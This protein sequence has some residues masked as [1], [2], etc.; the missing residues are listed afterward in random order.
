MPVPCPCPFFLGCNEPG[1]F[2]VS[3]RHL[4]R[5]G[6]EAHC[7][8]EHTVECF[9]QQIEGIPHLRE[10]LRCALCLLALVVLMSD[11]YENAMSRKSLAVRKR[12]G[13]QETFEWGNR[14]PGSGL[15]PET[16]DGTAPGGSKLVGRSFRVTCI[17]QDDL[18]PA[19]WPPLGAVY[20]RGVCEMLQYNPGITHL[21]DRTATAGAGPEI[22]TLGECSIPP[23]N[24]VVWR[25]CNAAR[26]PKTMLGVSSIQWMLSSVAWAPAGTRA[27]PCPAHAVV[28]SVCFNADPCEHPHV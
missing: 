19:W 6:H 20:R 1:D 2:R 4:A 22:R 18:K 15:T 12:L 14:T 10:F 5:A 3:C 27:C 21:P 16:A 23:S 8:E 13:E 25:P 7:L 9:H 28:G 17:G 26:V 24:Q 11:W